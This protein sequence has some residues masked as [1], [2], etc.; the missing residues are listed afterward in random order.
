MDRSER[1]RG[2]PALEQ[3]DILVVAAYNAQ[4]GTVERDLTEAGL[5]E[6]E[7]GTVDKFQGREAAVAIVSMAASAVED[8]PRG[9]SFLLSRNRLNVA[10]SA[11]SGA[12]SS[13][14]H[15]R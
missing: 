15:T 8:V 13:S 5:T 12:R 11:A 14:D 2:N 6:V 9:M 1:V 7:V 4:V 3:S 10:V